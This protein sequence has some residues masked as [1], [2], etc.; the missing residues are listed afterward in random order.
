[1]TWST[2]HIEEKRETNAEGRAH[3]KKIKER[4]SYNGVLPGK[5]NISVDYNNDCLTVFVDSARDLAGKRSQDPY[6]WV[7]LLGK[8]G[9]T[10]F[11]VGNNKTRTFDKNLSPAF[12]HEF[13]FRMSLDDLNSKSL[14]VSLWD[15]DSKS[16]DDYMAGVRLSLEH[17]QFF[18]HRGLVWLDLQ[19]Q[20][21]DGHPAEVSA[22]AIFGIV[23]GS[24]DLKTCNNHL[25]AFIDRARVLAE[26]YE[27]KGSLPSTLKERTSLMPPDASRLFDEEIL[28]L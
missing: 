3:Q 17:V 20:G 22:K 19:H 26:A 1:M 23:L 16:R 9:R 28:R 24:W 4:S 12:Q 21:F 18:Q 5:I 13:K 2:A 7:Y 25:V 11:Q 6:A 8:D 10:Y 14:I 27:I 15:E